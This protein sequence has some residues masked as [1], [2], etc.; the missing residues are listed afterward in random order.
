MKPKKPSTVQLKQPVQLQQDVEQII[1][2]NR[3]RDKTNEVEAA[4]DHRILDG[5]PE[6]TG[7]G[8]GRSW[9]EL[10]LEQRE[11]V[12]AV[13]QEVL[14]EALEKVLSRGA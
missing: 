4:Q 2:R 5:G 6:C 9:N 11:M 10:T 8:N 7:E 1:K 13:L 14:Q 12:R 3:T